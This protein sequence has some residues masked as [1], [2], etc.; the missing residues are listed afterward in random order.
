[1]RERFGVLIKVTFAGCCNNLLLLIPQSLNN[2]QAFA[3]THTTTLF[4]IRSCIGLCFLAEGF[5]QIHCLASRGLVRGHFSCLPF[6]GA[7]EGL[8]GGTVFL[9][10]CQGQGGGKTER[11]MS[12]CATLLTKRTSKVAVQSVNFKSTSCPNQMRTSRATVCLGC[13]DI[14]V[15]IYV[16]IY[17]C[18][19]SCMCIV[20]MELTELTSVAEV[21]VYLCMLAC[22]TEG[23]AVRPYYGSQHCGLCQRWNTKCSVSWEVTSAQQETWHGVS[24]ENSFHSVLFSLFFCCFIIK[25][26]T[27]N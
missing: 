9:W 15:F 19:F 1:M 10:L 7:V 24:S 21:C 18:V 11:G 17:K 22:V 13:E 27:Q 26:S 16:N 23:A 5:P 12:V 14:S 25:S 6:N 3:C 8:S 4:C 2:T 20:S